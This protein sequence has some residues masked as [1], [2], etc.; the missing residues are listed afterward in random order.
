MKLSKATLMLKLVL[1]LGAAAVAFVTFAGV[2]AYMGH[3]IHVRPDLA[4]WKFWMEAYGVL[5][6][7]PVWAVIVI[8][9]FVFDT[10]PRNEAFTRRNQ[11]RFRWITRLAGA[12]TAIVAALWVFLIASGVT[13]PFIAMS[14]SLTLA[15]GVVAVIVFYVLGGLVGY[16]ADL[17]QDSEL[18]I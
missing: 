1:A 17:K 2:P 9:W 18:T 8:L 15:A 11:Q 16:A 10:L 7:L 4:V 13:P 12:D 6:A 5:I 14:M 3:V